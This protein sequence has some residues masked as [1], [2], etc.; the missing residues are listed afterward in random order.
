MVRVGDAYARV[1]GNILKEA[2]SYR[3]CYKAVWTEKEI[4]LRLLFV[5]QWVW[6]LVAWN[7][8]VSFP[9]I[10][11]WLM[12]G[13]QEGSLFAAL[14]T[15]LSYTSIVAGIMRLLLPLLLCGG[16]ALGWK[17]AK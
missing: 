5:R 15:Y 9:P 16:L 10:Y 2:C 1:E 12:L 3:D 13:A 11:V 4:P 14:L 7:L 8:L 17:G 6:Q